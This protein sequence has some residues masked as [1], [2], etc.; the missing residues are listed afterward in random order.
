MNDKELTKYIPFSSSESS[1]NLCLDCKISSIF[2]E[3]KILFSSAK[4]T[5][6]TIS[7]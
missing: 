1:S 2:R 5:V 3:N 6:K 4:R 7:E